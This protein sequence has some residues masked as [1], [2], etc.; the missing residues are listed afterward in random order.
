MKIL[1]TGSTGFVG[2]Q[3]ARQ[4]L[5]KGHS[6]RAHFM[7]G[8]DLSRISDIQDKL[9]LVEGD[10]FNSTE[11]EL[12]ILC[13]GIDACVHSAWH[14]VPGK[15]LRAL[16][17]VNCVHGSAQLFTE[18]GKAGCKRCVAIGTCFE[19]D[20]KYGFLSEDT[21]TKPTSLYAA[22]K[23]S[24]F[25]I[26]EQISS[27]YGMSFAW[28]H[29]FYLY[30]PYED[31]RR[32]VPYVIDS[33]LQGVS[34]DVTSGVQVRD[35]LHV[36]DV[37]SAI[38]A[39][40]ESDLTGPVNIGSGLPVKVREIVSSLSEIIGRPDLVNLGARPTDPTDPLFICANNSKL[41]TQTDW[42]PLYDMENGLTQTVEWWKERLAKR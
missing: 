27:I 29:L 41:I 8:D 10:I 18:L 35:Y 3:V 33:L 32:L 22:A 1:L 20:S 21:P 36:E 17:N 31:A 7:Q 16:E 6:I 19:Y 30:G 14:A 42:K 15:Y 13:S 34:A 23:T 24:T 37:A 2:S 28:A 9:Q 12:S 39:V 5:Q 40:A 25:L 26:G 4:L 38:V 11:K